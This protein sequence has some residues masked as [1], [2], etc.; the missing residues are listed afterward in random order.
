MRVKQLSGKCDLR[1]AI[2]PRSATHSDDA[3]VIRALRID[4]NN[5]EIVDIGLCGP[6]QDEI[7]EGAEEAR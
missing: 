4:E 3:G 6:A 2:Q 7:A 5:P 1:S